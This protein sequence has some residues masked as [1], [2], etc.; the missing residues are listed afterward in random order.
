MRDL[1]HRHLDKEEPRLIAALRDHVSEP[2]WDAFSRE[3]IATAP[4]EQ[5]HLL[6]A[7]FDDVGTAEEVELILENLPAPARQLVPA[8]REQGR[9]VLGAVQPGS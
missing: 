5:S 1:V 4:A 6:I 7:L 3:V 9:A 8:M 2:A